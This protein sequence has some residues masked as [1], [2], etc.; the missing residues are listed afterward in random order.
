MRNQ[1][2]QRWVQ[3]SSEKRKAPALKGEQR[4]SY[5]G[6]GNHSPRPSTK[7]RRDITGTQQPRHLDHVHDAA[8]EPYACV[9]SHSYGPSLS[10]DRPAKAVPSVV[11]SAPLYNA[12]REEPPILSRVIQRTVVP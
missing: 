10:Q 12:K 11:T 6:L 8:S 4:T 1:S 3:I 5:P 9:E 7:F 2:K